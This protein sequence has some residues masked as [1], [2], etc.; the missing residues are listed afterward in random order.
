M[1][2]LIITV[3]NKIKQMMIMDKKIILRKP[4]L[5]ISRALKHNIKNPEIKPYLVEFRDGTH[6]IIK[7]VSVEHLHELLSS[8]D[9]FEGKSWKFITEYYPDDYHF[10]NSKSKRHPCTVCGKPT[11]FDEV[12]SRCTRAHESESAEQ[13]DR[14]IRRH[15]KDCSDP[16]CECKNY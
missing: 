10:F 3:K 8:H 12:C 16:D 2:L 4:R 13:D 6:A 14:E 1:N 5:D 15:I 11:K 7:A 9:E